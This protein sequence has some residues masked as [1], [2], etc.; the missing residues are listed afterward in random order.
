MRNQLKSY[1][2]FDVN[3][4]A[5][6]YFKSTVFCISHLK[7]V[8]VILRQDSLKIKLEKSFPDFL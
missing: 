8:I 5:S 3:L 2:N 4:S 6:I 7:V 1:S